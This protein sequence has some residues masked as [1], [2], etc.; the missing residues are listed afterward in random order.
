VRQIEVFLLA[1]KLGVVDG[2]GVDHERRNLCVRPVVEARL[3]SDSGTA[4]GKRK[5]YAPNYQKGYMQ[6]RKKPRPYPGNI[7]EK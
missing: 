3:I 7:S 6:T 5:A 2:F 4:A 1:P